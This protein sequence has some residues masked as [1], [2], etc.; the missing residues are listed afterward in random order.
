MFSI[1]LAET[2]QTH[3]DF[4]GAIGNATKGTNVIAEARQFL[5]YNIR[6]AN[7]DK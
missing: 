7:T 2:Y 5:E 1:K 6:L 4:G 3:Y